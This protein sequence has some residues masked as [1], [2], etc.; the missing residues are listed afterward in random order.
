M[1]LDPPTVDTGSAHTSGGDIEWADPS[2]SG[3]GTGNIEDGVASAL[4]VCSSWSN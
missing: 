4:G 1:D 3:T 2:D